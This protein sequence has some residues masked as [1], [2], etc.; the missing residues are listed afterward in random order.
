M[1]IKDQR[2]R[3]FR[4]SERSRLE[5]L[6]DAIEF[7]VWGEIIRIPKAHDRHTQESNDRSIAYARRRA[8]D[9]EMM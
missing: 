8:L 3:P 2:V 9:L 1:D 4:M 7:E 6:D 5:E